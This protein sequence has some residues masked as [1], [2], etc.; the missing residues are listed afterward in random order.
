MILTGVQT[1]KHLIDKDKCAKIQQVGVDL[2]V[3]KIYYPVNYNKVFAR[4]CK[5]EV[6]S[7][8]E[9]KELDPEKGEPFELIPGF[10]SVVFDQGVKIPNNLNGVIHTRSSLLRH[11]CNCEGGRYDSG[12]VSDNLGSML[13][14]QARIQIEKHAPIAQFVLY[15][16]YAVGSDYLYNGQHQGKCI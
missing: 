5:D 8:I 16:N 4:I 7:E 1:Y 13:F 3:K 9:W 12:Y 14:V 6:H 2:T 11:G 15:E 10:Y